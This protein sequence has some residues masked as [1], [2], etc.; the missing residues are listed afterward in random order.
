MALVTWNGNQFHADVL[1]KLDNGNYRVRARSPAPR[2]E[3]GTTIEVQPSEIT[4]LE[5]G[6]A[7]FPGPGASVNTAPQPSTLTQTAQTSAP[8]TSVN[9]S[10]EGAPQ[11]LPSTSTAPATAT[12]STKMAGTPKLDGFMSGFDS[13]T[14]KVEGLVDDL[15]KSMADTVTQVGA[16]TT[17]LGGAVGKIKAKAK[18]ME[19]VA[20][21]LSNGGPPL[22]N[23]DAPS[24]GS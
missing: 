19:D 4:Q 21:Q 7:T 1:A 24:S 11:P 17:K 2:V 12:T 16:S 3:I 5:I 10:L 22:G 9:P 20:N 6:G 14:A 13:F 15:N 8:I 23:S 18:Q